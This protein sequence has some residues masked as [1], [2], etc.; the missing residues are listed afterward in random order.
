VIFGGGG[1]S[2]AN[3]KNFLERKKTVGVG[4]KATMIQK[5]GAA[6][7]RGEETQTRTFHLRHMVC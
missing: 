4:P 3:H 5:K 2:E 1:T 7:A 6:L